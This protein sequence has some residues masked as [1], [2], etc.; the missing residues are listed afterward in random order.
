[1]TTIRTRREPPAFR[2]LEVVRRETLSPRLVRVV[3]GGDALAGMT[4]DLPA[5]SVRLLL[6]PRGRTD[7][8][9]PVWNGN[10]FLLPDGSRPAIRT[11]TPRRLEPR[12]P[13]LDVDVVVHEGGVLSAWASEA[14]PGS[15][16]AVSG[17]GRGYEIDPDAPGYLLAGDE[18]ALPGHRRSCSSTCRR[19]HP[20]R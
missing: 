7:L 1:M 8:V 14:V 10:E 4:L 20:P 17:P 12:A 2:T 6:P 5:A 3:L 11:L 18:T 15:G 16:V 13:E 9:M 19:A